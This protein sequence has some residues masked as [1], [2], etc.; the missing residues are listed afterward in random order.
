ICQTNDGT[1]I[2]PIQWDYAA[3]TPM[4]EKFITALKA[5]KLATAPTAYTIMITGVASPM[6]TQ[7]LA[8]REVNLVTKGLPGPLQ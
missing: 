7:E 3:W 1:L 2:V 5:E 4:T 6:A 8:A